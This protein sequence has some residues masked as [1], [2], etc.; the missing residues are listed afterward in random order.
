MTT[1]DARDIAWRPAWEGTRAAHLARLRTALVG[2]RDPLIRALV[3]EIRTLRRWRRYA[4]AEREGFLLAL[5]ANPLIQFVERVCH[6]GQATVANPSSGEPIHLVDH[7]TDVS[8]PSRVRDVADPILGAC[9]R[10][11]SGFQSGG[12]TWVVTV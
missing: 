11:R 3:D 7:R 8:S 1:L 4:Q 12:E 10:R 6:C 2:V 9:E 5:P